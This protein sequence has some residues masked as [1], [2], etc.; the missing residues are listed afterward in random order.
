MKETTKIIVKELQVGF[1][2][3]FLFL[4]TTETVLFPFLLE[5]QFYV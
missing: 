2:V 5:S 1:E 4:Q 3:F